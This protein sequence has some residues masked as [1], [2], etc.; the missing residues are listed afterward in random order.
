M[1]SALCLFVHATL[2]CGLL[3]SLATAAF[4]GRA[5]LTAWR[6]AAR[7]PFHAR[8]AQLR[9]RHYGKLL[10]LALGSA[11][12][13]VLCLVAI[14]HIPALRLV[15][16]AAHVKDGFNRASAAQAKLDELTKGI[17]TTNQTLASIETLLQKRPQGQPRQGSI[18]TTRSL[19][20]ISPFPGGKACE[21]LAGAELTQSIAAMAEQI[22]AAAA[23]RGVYGVFVF[24]M[25]DVREL[26]PD[27]RPRYGS[28]SA[29][30]YRRASCVTQRLREALSTKLPEVLLVPLVGGPEHLGPA[31]TDAQLRSDRQVVVTMVTTAT[32]GDEGVANAGR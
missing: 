8:E 13:A 25:H 22:N 30:A 6:T 4:A 27:S 23:S 15:D 7:T 26:G 28:N 1:L 19:S 14:Q 17:H 32:T 9:R 10:P 2:G 11:A 21:G 24:G 29:L 20:T 31:P 5:F 16:L 12:L 18:L 3:I